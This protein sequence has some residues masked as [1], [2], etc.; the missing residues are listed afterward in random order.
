MNAKAPDITIPK[1]NVT[2]VSAGQVTTTTWAPN[3]GFARSREIEQERKKEMEAYREKMTRED[4]ILGR[5]IRLE[6][7]VEELRKEIQFLKKHLK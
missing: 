4:P 6:E 7:T 1:Q 2:G 3:D 5:F